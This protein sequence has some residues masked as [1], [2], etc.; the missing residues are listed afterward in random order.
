MKKKRKI[1][2]FQILIILWLIASLWGAINIFS[3]S[4][5]NRITAGLSPYGSLIEQLILI[6]SSFIAL[7]F[8]L[9]KRKPPYHIGKRG[10]NT[11]FNITLLL[12]FVVLVGGV[13]VKTDGLF[14]RGGAKSTIPLGPLSIQP[15]EIYKITLILFLAKRFSTPKIY[16][17]WQGIVKTVVLSA[18]GLIL[19]KIEPD[20]GG[21]IILS[22]LILSMIFYNG[23]KIGT[24][25]KI[26]LPFMI[27]GI[28]LVAISIATSYQASRI[29]AWLHPF[30]DGNDLKDSYN[31]VNGYIAISNGGVFGS[32]FMNSVQKSG[33]VF[34]SNTDFIFTVICEEW[35]LFGASFTIGI[36]TL[37]ALQC[38]NIGYTAHERFGMLYS[39]GFGTL[40]LIQTFVNI[41][42]VIGLIPMTGVTLPFISNGMNS[43]LILSLGLIYVIVI[44]KERIRQK[45]IR[46]DKTDR[47]FMS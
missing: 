36:L 10:A 9:Q 26:L 2:K 3:A 4:A 41:G 15:L 29:V 44:D 46:D 28:I 37:I 43:Y 31:V 30:A 40:I 18:I 19:V 12:L 22:A 42:G 17:S 32:G 11:F 6:A 24:I 34:A 27:I 21:A 1:K 23:Q 25:L 7:A 35:G 13:L 33:F 14:I 45:K 39:Y 38:F 5:I 16:D 20:L 47:L 8:I